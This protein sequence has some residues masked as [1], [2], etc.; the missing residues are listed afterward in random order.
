MASEGLGGQGGVTATSTTVASSKI[1]INV[2]S[3]AGQRVYLIAASWVT[4]LAGAFDCQDNT[5]SVFQVKA[6][7]R[8]ATFLSEPVY[9]PAVAMPVSSTGVTANFVLDV[10]TTGRLSIF[11]GYGI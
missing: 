1:T 7:A 4:D 3:K 11:Y 5:T 2:A 6:E 10:T 8:G 9:T